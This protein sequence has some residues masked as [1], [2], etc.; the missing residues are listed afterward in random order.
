LPE[1]F[2]DFVTDAF[3][4]RRNLWNRVAKLTWYSR[5]LN[6]LIY[7]SRVSDVL[8]KVMYSVRRKPVELR[9]KGVDWR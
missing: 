6:H 7:F 2:P 5:H 9:A 8:H 3:Y 1:D 4:L